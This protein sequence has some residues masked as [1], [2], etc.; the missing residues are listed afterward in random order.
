MK[1]QH[2]S[3]TSRQ[4]TIPVESRQVSFSVQGSVPQSLIPSDHRKC[5]IQQKAT[6]YC[7]TIPTVW[8]TTTVVPLE[9]GDW[10]CFPSLHTTFDTRRIPRHV[11]VPRPF[12]NAGTSGHTEGVG[13]DRKRVKHTYMPAVLF[14]RITTSNRRLPIFVALWTCDSHN[15]HAQLQAHTTLQADTSIPI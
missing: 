15:S 6:H 7:Y 14:H 3:P 2:Q 5:P 1:I 4:A 13:R 10:S 8:Y 11:S 9:L 12:T